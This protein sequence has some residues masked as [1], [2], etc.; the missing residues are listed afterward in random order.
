M[1][2]TIPYIDKDKM[3]ERINAAEQLKE[4]ALKTKITKKLLTTVIK[5][6]NTKR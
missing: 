6:K 2:L 5:L 4:E 1:N 3:Q